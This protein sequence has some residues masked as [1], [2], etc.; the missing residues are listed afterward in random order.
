MQWH[1]LMIPH[2]V[3][4]FVQA[5]PVMDRGQTIQFVV[6]HKVGFE[7]GFGFEVGSGFE[8]GFGFEGRFELARWVRKEV[9]EK[10]GGVRPPTLPLNWSRA[11]NASYL[12]HAKRVC[13]SELYSS[14][15]LPTVL[16]KEFLDHGGVNQGQSLVIIKKTSQMTS[17]VVYDWPNLS[18]NNNNV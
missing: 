18:P 5:I 4:L 6:F 2:G 13:T 16:E 12:S 11:R 3:R 1:N 10:K 14:I 8:G 9:R 15:D 17:I 7:V